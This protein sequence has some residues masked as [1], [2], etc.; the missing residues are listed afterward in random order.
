MRR[1][2]GEQDGVAVGRRPR[3]LG[4]ADV[5]ERARDV[6]DDHRLPE[7]FLHLA[8]DHAADAV[9]RAAGA[10]RDDQPDRVVR[11][12]LR[13]GLSRGKGV[14]VGSQPRAIGG[15]SLELHARQQ[16]M[17]GAMMSRVFGNEP[18]VS[19]ADLSKLVDLHSPDVTFDGMHLKPQANATVGAA[20]VD[21]VLKVVPEQ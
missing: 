19:W 17:L 2:R 4:G 15:R 14:V 13:A 7:R 8:R 6:C 3:H 12:A 21:F 9:R 5:R 11:I 18:G 16:E 10:V 1:I 20:L